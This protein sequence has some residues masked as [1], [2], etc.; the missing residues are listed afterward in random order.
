MTELFNDERFVN[1]IE[2][3]RALESQ[4]VADGVLLFQRRLAA[5]DKNGTAA[6]VGAS[7]K[8]LSE[9]VSKVEAGIQA[10]I[11]GA[12]TTRGPK[13][14]ALAWC[15]RLGPDVAAYLTVKV[16]LNTLSHKLVVRDCANMI[17]SFFVDEL[18]FRRFKE[19]APGLFDYRMN[20]FTTSN[21]SHMARSMT[22]TLGHA[23]VDVSDL[24]MS[25]SIKLLVGI[26]LLDILVETTGLVTLVS[27]RTVK[28]TLNR[29]SKIRQE[30]YVAP[31]PETLEWLTKR[32]GVLA[33][34]TP[35]HPPMVVPPLPWESG[36][37]KGGYRFALRG[38][39]SVARGWDRQQQKSLEQADMP[40]VFAAVNA[41]QDTPWRINGDVLNL[42]RTVQTTGRALGGVPASQPEAFPVAPTNVDTDETVRKAH[43]KAKHMVHER[44]HARMVKAVTYAQTL[45]VAEAFEF[46]AAI[47]FPHNCDFRGRIYPI[48]SHLSPQGH[49]LSKGLLSFAEGKPLG[50]DGAHYLAVHGANCLG[51]TAEGQKLS[52]Q[53]LD[54]RARW[55]EDHTQEIGDA[56][57]DPLT[58][59][60]WATAD[61]PLQFFAFCCEWAAYKKWCAKRSAEDFISTLPVS[62]D[63][64]CNGLQHFSAMFR[65]EVGGSAVNL[66]PTDLPQDIYQRVA[67][68]VL[69]KLELLAA[70]DS[71]A[72]LWLSSGLITRKLTKRPVMTFGYGSKKYGF[73][74]QLVEY[75]KQHKDWQAIRETFTDAEG[76]QLVTI[77]CSLLAGLIHDSISE[78]V[79]AAGKGM[80]WLQ[81]CTREITKGNK[82]VE[83]RVPAT[84]FPVR[85]PYFACTK[86]QVRTILAGHTIKPEYYVPTN[87][88]LPAKQRNAVAPNVVHS[89]D[90]AAL[91]LTVDLACSEGIGHFA[92][93]HDS[94]GTL[95]AD[96]GLLADC[97][98]M[99]FV[100]LYSDEVDVI[101]NLYA[102]W[103]AQAEDVSRVP[104]PPP[105]G[106]LDIEQV[107]LS[108]FFF[109]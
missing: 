74:D 55:V 81:Q 28:K 87:E 84:G 18:R 100:K 47:F 83:W 35:L 22:A 45:Q 8:L 59:N 61:K 96:V 44:N 46:D 30:L 13:H 25:P 68:T 53:S 89:L 15:E 107:L 11:D 50:R 1:L 5:A 29:P 58:H 101:G 26:K 106:S 17:A 79:T 65:D 19:Q 108:T 16:V 49:D 12:T 70:G 14:G 75:M 98:R 40:L 78:T 10:L 76:K 88:V 56:A 2:R 109:S 85:Q 72:A 64:T 9:A 92:F 95:A 51:T 73:R 39:H 77:A 67:D 66:L 82:A 23:N 6:N 93:V 42:V 48:C 36:H 52:H 24:E 90:A 37:N 43:R 103:Q 63:G 62:Q 41:L 99:A 97:T 27:K 54:E 57:L 94:Y 86:K 91:M 21:Y 60:W 33:L 34:L 104:K 102:Q 4:A 69:G 7:K 105:I 71:L 20:S 80:A 32:N 38:R 3:Q 31:T